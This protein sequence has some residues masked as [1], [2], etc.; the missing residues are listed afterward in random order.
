MKRLVRVS[1][2][3]VVVIA[4]AVVGLGF[5]LQMSGVRAA[6]P[7]A[8]A[9]ATSTPST[10]TPTPSRQPTA[11]L[12]P[13][14]LHVTYDERSIS[15]LP[16]PAAARYTLTGGVTALETGPG[17]PCSPSAGNQIV[18]IKL[19]ESLP[20]EATSF[21]LTLPSLPADEHWT[22]YAD[23][24]D[25]RA[26]NREGSQVAGAGI[27]QIVEG[28]TF[29]SQPANSTTP[30]PRP[31][32]VLPSTGLPD[33]SAPIDAEIGIAAALLALG[34]AAALGGAKRFGSARSAPRGCSASRKQA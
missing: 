20:G 33:R 32:V 2:V 17:G 15:W 21:V 25:L 23:A 4:F 16:A 10:S 24:I 31:S 13:F 11:V 7:T 3:R 5:S 30:I 9:S 8:V 28:C 19:D 26:F 29:P 27:M 6:S 14:D 18:K 22:I 1:G 12:T 34:F